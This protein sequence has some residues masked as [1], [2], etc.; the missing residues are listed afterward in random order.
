MKY[1]A[2]NAVSQV[3]GDTCALFLLQ[4]PLRQRVNLSMPLAALPPA[5]D[6]QPSMATAGDTQAGSTRILQM[7]Q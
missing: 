2:K 4:V 5:G 3:C 1:E 6:T 7:V